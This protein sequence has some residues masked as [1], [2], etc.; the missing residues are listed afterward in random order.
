VSLFNTISLLINLVSETQASTFLLLDL[1]YSFLSEVISLVNAVSQFMLLCLHSRHVQTSN[2]QGQQVNLAFSL[3]LVIHT[4]LDLL[5]V[6][7]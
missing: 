2:E 4:L 7:R 5:L 6:V 1:I 3:L